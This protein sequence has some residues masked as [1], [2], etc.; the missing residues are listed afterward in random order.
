M[1]QANR[2]LPRLGAKVRTVRRRENLSQ[3]QLAERLGI[4]ASY[5]NL[6]ESNRP[7]LP[8]ALLLKLAQ[9]FAMDLHTSGGTC[10]P[11]MVNRLREPCPDPLFDPHP[12]TSA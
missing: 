6:L 12:L 9:L 3:V 11:P 1:A 7:P 10:A 4:S 2:E 5:L 8:A